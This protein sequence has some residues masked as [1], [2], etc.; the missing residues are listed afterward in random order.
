[1]TVREWDCNI[2]MLKGI[3]EIGGQFL[4]CFFG[5]DE[6]CFRRF[7]IQLKFVLCHPVFCLFVCFW[8]GFVFIFIRTTVRCGFQKS[9]VVFGLGAVKKFRVVCIQEVIQ[10][11]TVDDGG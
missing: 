10:A 8:W 7:T 3:D 9:V 4:F 1:M 6:H 5:S 11:V 2:I